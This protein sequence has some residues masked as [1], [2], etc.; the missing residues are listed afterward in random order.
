MTKSNLTTALA[1]A[2]LALFCV[3]LL[4]TSGAADWIKRPTAIRN[5]QTTSMD[6][7]EDEHAF[8]IDPDGQF[9]NLVP[10]LVPSNGVLV[11][12]TLTVIPQLP[13]SGNNLIT[14]FQRD[15]DE[16]LFSRGFFWVPNDRT[17]QLQFAAGIVVAG[18]FEIIIANNGRSDGEV[19][20]H[21]DGYLDR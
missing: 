1:G 3:A 8:P 13:D 9:D 7:G 17:T 11:V 6:P 2:L 21:L 18:D 20:V 10:Y 15:A 5:L 14:V 12:T 4:P 16:N 19:L